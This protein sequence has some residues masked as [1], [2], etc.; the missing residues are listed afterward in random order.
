MAVAGGHKEVA[1]SLLKHGADPNLA[2]HDEQTP[3]RV[4]CL[5]F[6]RDDSAEVFF[7]ACDEARRRVH[8]NARDRLDGNAPLHL[9]PER[10]NR[11]LANDEG[12]TALHIV[13][14]IDNEIVRLE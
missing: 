3:L 14:V 9:A 4:I 1:E 8:V 6:A 12:F 10:D 2:N 11:E 7:G 13:I 5:R